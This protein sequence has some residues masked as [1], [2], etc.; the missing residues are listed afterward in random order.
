M[1]AKDRREDEAVLVVDLDGTL[2]RSDSLYECFWA[3]MSERSSTFVRAMRAMRR[4]RV[5]VKRALAQP[6]DIDVT[7]LPYNEVVLDRVRE[8]R[9]A[10]GRSVLVSAADDALVRRIGDHLGIFDETRGSADGV[11]LKG[12]AKAR[13]VE[14]SF[15]AQ[16]YAYIGDSTADIAV[17]QGAARA[18]TVDASPALR[19]K[20]DELG[21]EAEHLTAQPADWRAYAQALRPHQW[22]KNVLVFVPMIAAQAFEW[23]VLLQSFLAFVAFSLVSSGGY[24]L[25]DLLDLRADRSHP[26]KR[27]RPLAAGRVPIAHGTFMVP[28]LLGPGLCL[29]ALTG[30]ALFAV[31]LVYFVATTVYSLL[32]KRMPVVDICTL[33]GLYTLRIVA[34]GLATG[35]GLSVWLL[36]FSIFFFF[37]MATVKR[38]AELVDL[39]GRDTSMVRRRGYHVN[40]LPLVAQMATASGYVSVLVLALY[41]NSDAVQEL[42]TSP[43][44]LWSICL[45]LL[46]WITRTVLITHR[47]HMDDDPVIY[48]IKDGASRVCI[49]LVTLFTIGAAVL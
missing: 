31:M 1:T 29:A 13:F 21:G 7:T 34:G 47:G 39:A 5:A 12:A 3:G 44:L 38:Q 14:D 16:G 45:I 6:E 18:I 28:L 37:S 33:A 35:L 24:V 2:I 11:N 40:D 17:W 4:G 26:R 30:S 43:W 15:G 10:G 48:A 32:L 9:K 23:T 36:A 27:F 49:L 20:V 41:L 19:R 46:Y 25:N 8:W 22:L 42:Y